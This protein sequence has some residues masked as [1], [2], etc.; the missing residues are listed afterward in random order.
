MWYQFSPQP[1]ASAEGNIAGIEKITNKVKLILFCFGNTTSYLME[2]FSRS[3]IN[4]FTEFRKK[5]HLKSFFPPR[6]ATAVFRSLKEVTLNHGIAL[7][8]AG[9]SLELPNTEGD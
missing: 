3:I 9:L 2:S 5:I 1:P 7:P 6:S 8:S 4:H